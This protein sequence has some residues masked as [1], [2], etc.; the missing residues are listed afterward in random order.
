[1]PVPARVAV[2]EIGLAD[3]LAVGDIDQTVGNGDADLHVLD[4]VA[5]LILVGPPDAGA[6]A[7]AGGVDPRDGRP[8]PCPNVKPPKRPAADGIAGVVE[9]DG[10]DVAGA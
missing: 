4:F 1:M 2:A 7:F 5:P 3:E 9:V 10:V 8:D 6:L